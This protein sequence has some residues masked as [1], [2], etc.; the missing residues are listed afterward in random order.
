MI[1][2]LDEVLSAL[3]TFPTTGVRLSVGGANASGPKPNR[4]A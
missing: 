1:G 4:R 3:Q 2:V